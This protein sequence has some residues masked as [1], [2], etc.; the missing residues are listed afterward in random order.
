M[1]IY[2]SDINKKPL[3]P[4]IAMWLQAFS[5]EGESNPVPSRSP[6]HNFGDDQD[7]RS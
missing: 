2:Y 1:I 5:Q 3:S 7:L 4:N 6:S